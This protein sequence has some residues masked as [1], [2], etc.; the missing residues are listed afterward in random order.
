VDLGPRA[1]VAFAFVYLAGQAALIM[2]AGSRPDHAFG[3]RMFSESSTMKVELTREIEAPSGNGY[4]SVP[5]VGGTWTARDREGRLHR[6]AW[7]D[8]IRETGLAALGV[9]VPA[10]YGVAAQ[11]ARLAA[12]LDD[13]AEHI[14]GDAET[15]RLIADVTLRKN[16]HEPTVAK[17]ASV[18]R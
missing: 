16:G 1:R 12:A 18:E 11:L 15:H 4:V 2:T 5:V 8:R 7:R 6:F 17:L 14:E 10:S 9:T 3:F 13:V